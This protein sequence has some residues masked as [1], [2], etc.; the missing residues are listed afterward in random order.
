MYFSDVN[1][2][3]VYYGRLQ[4]SGA[5]EFGYAMGLDEL[6]SVSGTASNDTSNSWTMSFAPAQIGL[7]GPTGPTGSTGPMGS[8]YPVW[9]SAGNIAFTG[10]SP[11]TPT[12]SPNASVNNISYRQIGLRQWE[13]SI[14]Y[15]AGSTGGTDGA[16][17]YLFTLPNSL[18]FD[19]TLPMQPAYQENVLG[20]GTTI[21]L[22]K[23]AL[24]ASG[25]MTNESAIGQASPIIW[26]ATRFRILIITYGA[27]AQC[28]GSL[29]YKLS[30]TTIGINM[31]FQFTST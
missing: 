5:G 28:W 27:I 16:G 30:P 9:T 12:A 4:I 10:T 6:V 11:G 23:Y 22:A 29:Y 15:L 25:I 7:T 24:P 1:S 20:A 14:T 2:D 8:T 13:I 31:Q 3:L 26:D 21:I 18:S 19:T 17:D